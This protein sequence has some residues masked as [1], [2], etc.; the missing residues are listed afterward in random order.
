MNPPERGWTG[1]SKTATN[2]TTS[3]RS[4]KIQVQ[5]EDDQKDGKEQRPEN[6]RQEQQPW[7]SFGF[8]VTAPLL[9]SF[10]PRVVVPFLPPA[11]EL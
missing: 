5:P 8:P 2:K 11:R 1:T 7:E 10:F 6:E 9:G 3:F 4:A